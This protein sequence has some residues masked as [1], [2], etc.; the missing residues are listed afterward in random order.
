M[1]VVA[2]EGL[3]H[4]NKHLLRAGLNYINDHCMLIFNI[5]ELTATINV[6]AHA[7]F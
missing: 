4:S 7:V 1:Q 6:S 5:E 3:M 2:L